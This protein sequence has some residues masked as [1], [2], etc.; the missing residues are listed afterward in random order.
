MLK[1][2]DGYSKVVGTTYQGSSNH[3]L[4]SNGGVKSISDFALSN[5]THSYLPLAGGTMN[6]NARIS[7]NGDLYIGNPDN[8]GWLYLQDIASQDGDDF[9]S[10]T[11]AG[12]AEFESISIRD[13]ISVTADAYIGG[14]ITREGK[15]SFWHRG[16]DNALIRDTTS[17]GY[18][19]LWSLKTKDGSWEFGEY[20]NPNWYNIP[21][22][23][24]ITDTDYAAN[25]NQ[26]TYQQKFQLDSGTIALTKNIPNPTNYYWANVKVSA[27]SND[28]TQPSVN[29]IYAS[30]WFRSYGASGW[31]SDSYGGGIYMTDSN[32][33]RVF[34]NKGFYTKNTIKGTTLQ[35]EGPSYTATV[36]NISGKALILGNNTIYV[37]D[38][39]VGIGVSPSTTTPGSGSLTIS[40]YTFMSCGGTMFRQPVCIFIG[41]FHHQSKTKSLV[42]SDTNVEFSYS[43]NIYKFIFK[44]LPS[45]NFKV[46]D[47]FLQVTGYNELSNA[48]V[49]DARGYLINGSSGYVEAYIGTSDDD[50]YNPASF[51][52]TIYRFYAA[53]V[54]IF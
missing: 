44:S 11:T 8:N 18:H 17:V 34:N 36:A 37:K 29:T 47:L 19:P 49:V 2:K 7:T 23:S 41:N 15:N 4:L 3:L 52:F 54:T 39:S 43:N 16:R 5:H 24:Y 26:I 22:L 42:A 48:Q 1:T 12:V 51:Y 38:G 14:Q 28:Q 35:V 20:N 31:C 53:S 46:S 50:N 21:V 32:W 40:N 33:I 9:W 45:K 30:N 13:N 10:I 25:N 27:S 6:D